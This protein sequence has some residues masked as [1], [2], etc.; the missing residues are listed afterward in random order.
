M[1]DF[2]GIDRYIKMET[3]PYDDI[4]HIDM[5]MKLLDEETLLVGQYPAG[6]ADGPQIEANLNYVLNNF[7]TPFGNPYHVVRIPM[8]PDGGNDYPNDNGDY[9]TYANCV[10][11]NKTVLVPTYE[12]EYDTTGLRILQEQLPGYNVVG[13]NC[14]N[15][16][17][18]L[19]ALHCITKLV[20]TP[21]P[22]LDS[23]CSPA[24]YRPRCRPNRHCSYS[25]PIRHCQRYAIL[26]KQPHR[27]RL[28]PMPCQ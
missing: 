22:A 12:E 23:P 5:H 28:R 16:I 25:A 18:S 24:R 13:I 7:R 27:P 14:N 26:Y 4:H 19:G 1:A 2:M 21:R 10:F 8:P 6:V 11:V 17:T 3:L 20:H 15:I 9:R